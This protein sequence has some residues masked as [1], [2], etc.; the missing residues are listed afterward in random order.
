MPIFHEQTYISLQVDLFK[1]T[2]GVPQ[3]SILGKLLFIIYINDLA[4][5]LK[6]CRANMY[7]VAPHELAPSKDTVIVYHQD[8]VAAVPRISD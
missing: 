5:C 6:K 8:D 2:T 3:G 1:I 7:A 4:N